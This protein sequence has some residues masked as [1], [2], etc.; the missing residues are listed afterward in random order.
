MKKEYTR[1]AILTQGSSYTSV[2]YASRAQLRL[3]L[4]KGEIP[5][6]QLI[7]TTNVKNYP[8]YQNN[9]FKAR[10]MSNFEIQS[11]KFGLILEVDLLAQYIFLFIRID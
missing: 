4:C 9:T 1:L 3:V 5:K 11:K 6:E 2:I 7:T 10:I 8:G